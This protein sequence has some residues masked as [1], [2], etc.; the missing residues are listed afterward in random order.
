MQATEQVITESTVAPPRK[1]GSVLVVGPGQRGRGGIAAVIRMHQRTTTWERRRTYHLATFDDR[2]AFHKLWSA[3]AA[4]VVAPY[5][6]LRTDLAHVHLAAQTSILR[7][8]PIL[9][10]AKVLRRPVIVHVHAPS[11]ESLFRD[12]KPWA[13]RFTF[14][15]AA[16]VVALSQS[17]ADAF[18]AYEPKAR[19][20]V[21]ANP[22]RIF[23]RIQHDPS[24][25]P[26]VLFVG[27]LEPRK[28][29]GDLLSAAKLV[30]NDFPYAQ[31]WFAGHGE[32]DAARVQAEKLGIVGSVRF[33]GWVD[34]NDLEG[35][36]RQAHVVALPS[37]AEG[38]PMCIIE[39]MSHGIPVVCTPVGGLP[40]LIRD[41]ENGLFVI[42]GDVIGLARQIGRL[43]GEP[44]FAA[45]LGM[46]GRADVIHHCAIEHID[47][48]LDALYTDVL[49]EAVSRK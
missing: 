43:L 12:T 44:K 8:I 35:I 30:L 18:V 19:V 47:A 32:V 6:L 9:W 42:P 34:G 22:V 20:V 21:L 10:M 28:G 1:D 17:W 24:A 4:Y 13:M 33:L 23:D 5:H 11:T 7:K 38:V 27:K 29:Y 2:S 40:E 31:F 46:A 37:Y 45:T 3:L 14:R 16:R 36:Y 48:A 39:G 49:G 15:T 41:G 26:V 25:A